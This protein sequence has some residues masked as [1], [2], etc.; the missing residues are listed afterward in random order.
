MPASLRLMRAANHWPHA[1]EPSAP[2]LQS[3]VPRK[4]PGQTPSQQHLTTLQ[5]SNPS[6]SLHLLLSQQGAPQLCHYK[7]NFGLLE[8][9]TLGGFHTAGRD[10]HLLYP[11]EFKLLTIKVLTPLISQRG[12]LKAVYRVHPTYL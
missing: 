1:R 8:P 2:V 11:P 7:K 9:A 5:N 12:Q 6:N 10:R 4:P 3:R